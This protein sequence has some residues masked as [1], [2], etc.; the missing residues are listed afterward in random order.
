MDIASRGSN[1]DA[2][3]RIGLIS[4]LHGN[5]PAL[6]AVL[7]RLDGERIDELIC[8]G[9]VAVGPLA[10]DTTQ[11]LA[12]Q[13]PALV[14]GN[15]DAWVLDAAPP[16]PDG[17][18]C[19][20]LLEMAVFWVQE[21]D[22]GDR[23]FLRRAQPRLDLEVGGSRLVFWH[24]SPRSYNES[25]LATTPGDDLEST[26]AAV[27]ARMSFVGHTHLQ[28]IRKLASTVIVNPGSVGLP[29]REWPAAAAR[30]CPW[31]EYGIVEFLGEDDVNVE[32][33]RVPYDTGALIELVLESGVPHA[34]WWTDCWEPSAAM[35][36]PGSP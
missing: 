28:M 18:T 2:E 23:A 16:C 20:K 9:D 5:L 36:A 29:F 8:L 31:A 3:M 22:D 12:E 13:A 27:G 32:L 7:S 19:R 25:I 15:W 17:E 6:E 34:Q 26:F 14:L 11:L 1:I 24:A 33:R 10:H 21:L 4:D 35:P 30:V